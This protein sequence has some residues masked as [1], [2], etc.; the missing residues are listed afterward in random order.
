MPSSSQNSQL[1]PSPVESEKD[2]VSLVVES[3]DLST[4]KLRVLWK[5]GGKYPADAVAQTCGEVV[6]DHLWRVFSWI[7]ASSLPRENNTV[8]MGSHF[9]TITF[10]P[11]NKQTTATGEN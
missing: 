6:E 9:F 2:E 1:N 8:K 3:G 10:T 11:F 5:E 4:H 7:F